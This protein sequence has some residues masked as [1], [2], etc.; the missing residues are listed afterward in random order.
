MYARSKV[1]WLE[2]KKEKYVACICEAP[3]Q[4]NSFGCECDCVSFSTR[5]IR[6]TEAE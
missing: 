4:E 2:E 5:Q 6:Q 3:H 1:E